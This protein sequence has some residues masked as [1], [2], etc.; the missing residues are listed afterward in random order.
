M[1]PK[2]FPIAPYLASIYQA[3][4]TNNA[5]LLKAPT[6]SGK[7]LAIPWMLGNLGLRVFCT[8]VRI[9]S[10]VSLAT[11]QQIISPNY[12]VGYGA[13]SN[14][15][16]DTHSTAKQIAYVTAGHFLKKTL[17]LIK[18][19][20]NPYH[21]LDILI[22]DDPESVQDTINLALW[23][24]VASLGHVVPRLILTS[25]TVDQKLFPNFTMIDINLQNHVVQTINHEKSYKPDNTSVYYD[26]AGVIVKY[27]NTAMIG[28]FLAFCPGKEEI[29][30]VINSLNKANLQ[31]V[32]ILPAYSKLGQDEIQKIY[33]ETP[34]GVRKI[35]IA[36]NIAETAITISDLSAVFDSMT[37]KL[38]TTTKSGSAKLKVVYESKESSVQRKG[39][40]GRN[41]P[42]IYY[43]MI[44]EDDYANI[45]DVQTPA[46]EREPLYNVTMDLMAAG[47]NPIKV[48]PQY[49]E[50]KFSQT[51]KLL[52]KMELI[53]PTDN[54]RWTV[55]D[56][57]NFSA[58]FPLSV[59]NSAFIWHWMKNITQSTVYPAVI[60]AAI[61]DNYGPSL[62]YFP[63]MRKDENYD[64]YQT[65]MGHHRQKYFNKFSGSSDLHVYLKVWL[66]FS[67]E[68]KN[69]F[70][71]HY[72]Q[73][74]EW[75]KNN[76]INNKKLN[77]IIK[78]AQQCISILNRMKVKYNFKDLHP[79]NMSD[80]VRKALPFLEKVYDDKKMR[81]SQDRDS[82]LVY[83][84]I[85]EKVNY[86]LYFNQAV[87]KLLLSKPQMII[88]L[89]DITQEKNNSIKRVI[90]FA[91]PIYSE[92]NEMEARVANEPGLTVQNRSTA[93]PMLSRPGQKTSN[94]SL[95][96]P[97]FEDGSL[98][99]IKTDRS[100]P[101]I[102]S[103]DINIGPPTINISEALATSGVVI[104]PTK[105]LFKTMSFE[106]YKA[107]VQSRPRS[108]RKIL[109]KQR[110]L[111]ELVPL[112]P[113]INPLSLL[114]IELISKDEIPSIED[115][116]R[117]LLSIQV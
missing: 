18:D 78:T 7:S 26:M 19:G 51:T 17:N 60:M 71:A 106:A 49:S 41:M 73:I 13:E 27:H 47:L 62:L 2:T 111:M 31:N 115:S 99:L 85:V 3:I 46:I 105:P 35:I 74:K 4:S 110:S 103:I 14:V 44:T 37:V 28:H 58:N 95:T 9:N 96:L 56:L 57:G 97:G 54:E 23:N 109:Y 21:F 70:K 83:Y 42:G 16:Y 12:N 113:G 30:I 66:V 40:T 63:N 98:K 25:A 32:I 61:I 6:G 5:I 34:V 67:H 59:R 48:V 15:T 84:S 91:L 33:Q 101:D 104:E 77:E 86:N 43:A 88:S 81:L 38:M 102:S 87:N 89:S 36:T 45:P 50:N 107:L 93:E 80:M 39:R 8:E 65:R 68:V 112:K 108:E 20:K 92:I 29:D 55:T 117:R 76:S 100:L 69:P 52:E 64:Q 114:T 53:K 72:K 116:I 79:N 10:A 24:Y 1:D 22:I 82:L 75:S 11:N 90:S 94:L